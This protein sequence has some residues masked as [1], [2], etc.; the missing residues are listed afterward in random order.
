MDLS[1]SAE[2]RAFRAEVRGFFASH[3]PGTLRQKVQLGQPATR[4]ELVA[5]CN[6]LADRGWAVPHWPT[7]WG[8]AG[9]TTIQRHIFLEESYLASAPQ[10]PAF[11]PSMVG[12]VLYTFGST[13]QQQRFLPRI[14]RLQDWW[15]QGFSE[16]NAGSDLASL[17]CA[18]VQDGSDWVVNGQKIWTTYAHYA[19]W[20]FCLVR[21]NKEAKQQEGIGFLLIDM[22][23]PGVS[24]RPIVTL[25]GGAEVNEVWF[26]NVRVPGANM[27]GDPRKGWD[28]AKFL[29]SN[30][31]IGIARLGFTKERLRRIRALAA[32]ETEHGRPLLE[33]RG[34]RERLASLEVEL[35]ALELTQLRV[36]AN[37]AKRGPQGRPD[38]ATSIL[39]LKGTELQQAATELLM[40]LAAPYGMPDMTRLAGSNDLPDIPDWAGTATPHY[41]NWRKVSI[42]GG[43]SEIQKNIVAKAVLGL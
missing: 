4:G 24:V 29:L 8:G 38:P 9:W 14:P 26:D 16:P 20:I 28:Y 33:D 10:P 32:N 40:E 31:R 37:D 7:A 27:V 18:A 21:T 35:K 25:D 3:L 39:K 1:F 19:T 5:W 13:E 12:P 34:F 23:S 6:T 43:S 11:G 22:A 30:E 17:R 36:L 2:E 15:C 41:L 42:Y